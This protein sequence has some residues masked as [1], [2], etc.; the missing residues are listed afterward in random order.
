MRVVPALRVTPHG[1]DNAL[2]PVTATYDPRNH[3][4]EISVGALLARFLVTGS[5]T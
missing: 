1:S 5:S 4:N 3:T 2:L